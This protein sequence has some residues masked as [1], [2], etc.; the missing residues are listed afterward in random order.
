MNNIVSDVIRPYHKPVII[1]G[2]E[3]EDKFAQCEKCLK[4]IPL[5]YKIG[6]K[7][8]GPRPI[9]LQYNTL[10]QWLCESCWFAE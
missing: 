3:I 4:W 9:Q 1:G 5:S 7:G 2:P 10:D 8:F 6:F